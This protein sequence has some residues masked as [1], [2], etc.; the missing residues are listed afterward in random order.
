MSTGKKDNVVAYTVRYIYN[1]GGESRSFTVPNACVTI[2]GTSSVGYLESAGNVD[3]NFK[4]GRTFT[5][6]NVSYTTGAITF[7]DGSTSTKGYSLNDN[8]IPVDYLNV[9]V[10]V[11]S[12]ENCNNACNADWYNTYQ[13]WLSPARAKNSKARDTMEFVAGAIFI[14]DRSGN[15]FGDTNNY[16]FYGICD[17]GNSKKN[18]KVFHDTTNPIAVCMEVSNNTSLPCLMSSD[19]Y[20]WNADDDAVTQEIVDGELKEQKVYE[21]RYVEDGMEKVGEANWDR[22][23]KFMVHWNPNLATNANLS[24]PVTF[25]TYTFKGSGSYDTS[26][27]DND[28]YKVVYLYG[29]GLPTEYN[30]GLYSATDYISDTSGANTCYYYINYSNDYVYSSDGSAWTA[31][32]KLTWTPDRN[33]VL[34]G[35]N[36]GTYA[37]TYTKDSFEYRM[38]YMLAHCEEYM[39][40]D[41]VIYHFIFIESFLMTDNVAKNTF[42]STDDGVHWELSKDYD[43]DTSLGNDNVGGLS[44]TY[45][46][47]TD[48][49]VGA[50]YVFN[51]HDASWI[52]FARNLFVA[53]QVM[54]RNRESAGC[55]NSTNYLTKAKQYQS[56]RPERVWVADAQRKY[57]RP[58][59]DNGTETYLP[60]LAGKKTHQ[61]EQVKTYNAYYYA[62]KYVSDF[63]TSQ[64]IMVRGNTPTVWH[65]VRP[66]NTATL[67]MYID[68]YIIVASTSYN[69]VAKTRA[70]RGQT[71]VMD[72]ST[73]G[74]MGETE[75][76]FCTA[77]MITELSGLAHLYF[78]QN[79]FA[80]G[81]NLQRLE[82]GSN[83]AGY[84]NPNLES[85]TI[86]NNKMLE[87]LDVRNCP[88]VSGALD[89]SG[90]ISLRELYLENTNFTG[91]SI[92]KGGLLETAHLDSPTSI[93]MIELIY[94]ND[95]KL[96]STNSLTTLRVENC[97][98][99][100]TATLTIDSTVT[101]QAE[102]DIVLNLIDSSNNLSRVRLVGVNWILSDTEVLDRA[103]G[104]AGI[105]DD[106]FDIQQS[107]LT[108][109]AY[110][111]IIK[112]SMLEKYNNIWKYLM[113]TYD[114]VIAQ[115]TANFMN[116]DGEPIKDRKGNNYI[117]YVDS[118]EP[119]YDPVTMGRS[120]TISDDGIPD[121]TKYPPATYNNKYYL[122]KANG[123]IY[124]SNGTN[125]V[126]E[127]QC[128]ILTPSMQS[129]GQYDYTYDGWDDITSI[130]IFDKTITAKYIQ[131]LKTYRVRWFRERNYLLEEQ[132]GIPYGTE[133]SYSGDTLPTWTDGETTSQYRLFKGWDRSTGYITGDTDV[134][135]IWDYSLLPPLN[136]PMHE[137]TL[138]QIYGVARSDKQEEYGWE[139]LDY[140]DVT[141]GK[142]FDFSQRDNITPR[143]NGR[144]DHIEIGKDVLLPGIE[145][146]TF[147]SGGYYFDGTK[148][149][150]T[151]IK[152]FDEDSPSFTMAIDFQFSNTLNTT[153]LSC[154]LDSS[155]SLLRLYNNGTNV[156][157]DWGGVTTPVGYTTCRDIVV[158]RHQ[159]GSNRLTIYNAGGANRYQYSPTVARSVR[160]RETD[161]PVSSIPLTFGGINVNGAHRNYAKGHIHW[162][163]IWFEDLGDKNAIEL[164]SW[165]HEKVR[166]EYW[167]KNN[168]YYYGTNELC[169][170]SFISNNLLGYFSTRGTYWYS[171]PNKTATNVGGWRDSYIKQFC[172]ERIYNGMPTELQALIHNVEVKSSAGDRSMAILTA[173]S[174]IYFPSY[175][176]MEN[177]TTA[178]YVDEVGETSTPISW[179]TNNPQRIK[180]RGHI[181]A[182]KG[183]TN[184]TIYDNTIEGY[185][186]RLEPSTVFGG[187]INIKPGDIWINA[188]NS[189]VGYMFISGEE[190]DHYGITSNIIQPDREYVPSGAWVPSSTYWLRSPYINSDNA[191]GGVNTPGY[192]T[193]WN[194]NS[195]I[196]LVLCVSI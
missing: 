134:F 158:M 192:T 58:Y 86:G 115:Y 80:M 128:D 139:D 132:T 136:T 90:C 62:S 162:C 14:R 96:E 95:L 28:N 55:F 6:D 133:V 72:F 114:T 110:V 138:A 112:S 82:I 161:L 84:E 169:K 78:K 180:F 123:V 31:I 107:V 75:L 164:A 142:D 20:E 182:Y 147:V 195:N 35:V 113:I 146:D 144:I 122:D 43:N 48:D 185:D 79:N 12:S 2:Q 74:S 143:P 101:T 57:L 59:E 165:V 119:P 56:V 24:S 176:E 63:C 183:D 10:N 160:T 159:K 15:L 127:V 52:T 32:E 173:N 51:A 109:E 152:L 85:L 98:F 67:S 193:W 49:T 155:T 148:A 45:G 53:D 27:Y 26:S 145:K 190:I 5:S 17:I 137:M 34:G 64:N 106:S 178:P 166:F 131:T 156:M 105:D 196:G 7:D 81:T 40:I 151:D 68:C 50:S 149:V 94:V 130:V 187:T 167:R 23:A 37:G 77:P 76:Y 54:Y 44:F 120:I 99:A 30:N 102:K 191:A 184:Y 11:A 4:N 22:F 21:F 91:I 61:R 135:A 69:V 18:T 150:T 92:A 121:N 168:Y 47:E 194:T 188:A 3:I 189:S 118:G 19:D 70:K 154:N 9:K 87:Y 125:W 124:L 97:I 157:L 179:F 129:T 8:S 33:S 41:P 181:R 140:F 36:V 93:S 89:L 170:A 73:I 126:D 111:P 13:P 117:Q 174:K 171:N 39:V 38:A 108:G 186:N 100:P 172:D 104:F 16:H 46:L 42:W 71:Y 1:S 163:K 141:L 88:N 175:K 153:L 83:V 66:A 29:Y 177:T 103:L 60:M 25:G 65:G 116:A